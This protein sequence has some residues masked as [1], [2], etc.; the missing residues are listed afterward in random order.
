VGLPEI[1]RGLA[2]F[3]RFI[4]QTCSNF[5]NQ[6]QVASWDSPIHAEFFAVVREVNRQALLGAPLPT[7][8]LVTIESRAS[9]FRA[10]PSS[11]VETHSQLCFRVASRRPPALPFPVLGYFWRKREA[12]SLSVGS[13]SFW[14]LTI[15]S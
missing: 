6:T 13:G 15:A 7:L 1:D 2:P 3:G 4:Y 11:I 10:M 8:R 14:A 12:S 5:G 9:R